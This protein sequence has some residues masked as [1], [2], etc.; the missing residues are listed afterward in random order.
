MNLSNSWV[1][2]NN[3]IKKVKPYNNLKNRTISVQRIT[4]LKEKVVNINTQT[5]PK[6][7]KMSTNKSFD[8]NPRTKKIK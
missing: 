3:N 7:H 5:E 1:N 2:H 6:I 4:H 8:G